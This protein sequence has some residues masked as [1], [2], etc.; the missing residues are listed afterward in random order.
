MVYL[1][2]T[3]SLL[4]LLAVPLASCIAETETQLTAAPLRGVSPERYGELYQPLEIDGEQKWRCL[5]DPEILLSYDQI[6]DNYCDCPDGSDEPGTSA[7]SDTRSK[8]EESVRFFCENKGFKS[9]YIDSSKVDDG[10]CDCC[11]CSD[12]LRLSADTTNN[13]CY[14][15]N[16][17][18]EKM[19]SEEKEKNQRG[20]AAFQ[21]MLL[22]TELYQNKEKFYTLKQEI[23]NLDEQVNSLS[24]DLENLKIK[25]NGS[26]GKKKLDPVAEN[27][28]NLDIHNNVVVPLEEYFAS[29]GQ[30]SLCYNT[31]D[32]L[33]KELSQN[34]NLYLNDPVV[35]ENMDK[36]IELRDNLAQKENGLTVSANFE[37]KQLGQL[38]NFYDE[39]LYQLFVQRDFNLENLGSYKELLGKFSIAQAILGIKNHVYQTMINVIEGDMLPIMEDI[40]ANYQQNLKDGAVQKALTEFE[41]FKKMYPTIPHCDK[42]LKISAQYKKSIEL[43]Q[44]IIL[45]H[46][47]KMYQHHERSESL[48]NENILDKLFYNNLMDNSL[49]EFAKDSSLIK[50]LMANVHIYKNKKLQAKYETTNTNLAEMRNLK[51]KMLEQLD[52]YE[53]FVEQN[54]TETEKILAV[55]GKLDQEKSSCV[56]GIINKYEYRVCL[57]KPFQNGRR[58]KKHSIHQTGEN[59]FTL[60]SLVNFEFDKQDTAQ[61]YLA[62]LRKAHLGD[63]LSRYFMSYSAKAEFSQLSNGNN[64]LI[65]NYKHGDKCW[66][67]PKRSAKAYFYCAEQFKVLRVF[68]ASKCTYE[69]ELQGPLGCSLDV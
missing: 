45:E 59:T 13:N 29:V 69:V 5:N 57:G 36:Y 3:T 37:E 39:E 48:G 67:G 49:V 25:F 68:E 18:F 41:N 17:A 23:A 51:S 20:K 31:L 61:K 9:Y 42:T 2:K 7:C 22:S 26:D 24:L 8:N 28:M 19:V 52:Y 62:N 43:L 12:E 55:L 44:S 27:F 34:Y 58:T 35:N 1:S 66:K 6:N 15:M 40:A 53:Q 14:S 33:I 65:L 21:N 63:I 64:G 54:E 11:D 10:I 56:P 38:I 47:S 60:G 32:D 4:V 50:N 46:A 16:Q 30:V